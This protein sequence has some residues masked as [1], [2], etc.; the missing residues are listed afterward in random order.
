MI[1][2]FRRMGAE[3]K[4]A[5]GKI[6]RDR[7]K[8]LGRI[9]MA[10]TQVL[11]V[12]IFLVILWLFRAPPNIDGW[13]IGFKKDEKG[14]SYVSDSTAC[15]LL[16]VVLFLLPAEK[17]NIFCWFKGGRPSY[18]PILK[19][20]V[21]ANKLPWGVIVLL[22]GGF[23]IAKGSDQSGL[24]E[25]LGNELTFFQ[26]YDPW[27]MNL[28][29]SL[30]VAGATEV[31]SN[32]ATAQLLLP[33]LRNMSISIGIHPLY[34]MISA[35]IACSFAF[36]LPVATPPNAIALA[37]LPMNI[38]AIMCLTF[39]INAWGKPMFDLD[40]FPSFIDTDTRTTILSSPVW[41]TTMSALTTV[42]P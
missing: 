20:A 34:L 30:I 18:N 1:R 28:I 2:C 10:E 29:I 27:V 8:K 4:L 36:M 9:S 19:W 41:N 15:I 16:S 33:V 37:G 13:G 12:F 11:V 38:I 3:A 22:G 6:V 7:Y 5:I 40:T 17:P 35:T 24:S 21:V 39:A 23:A 26:K 42:S 32:T 25:W 31:T 14:K